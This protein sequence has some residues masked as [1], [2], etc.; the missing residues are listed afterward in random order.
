MTNFQEKIWSVKNK[1][2]LVNLVPKLTMCHFHRVSKELKMKVYFLQFWSDFTFL[3]IF[4]FCALK[5]EQVISCRKFMKFLSFLRTFN[6][7]F[8]SLWKWHHFNFGAKLTR[9][10]LLLND[11]IFSGKFPVNEFHVRWFF[12]SPKM[13]VRRVF[14]FKFDDTM[15]YSF[16]VSFCNCE[17]WSRKQ[18]EQRE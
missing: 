1:N 14:E 18:K 8:E 16:K 15:V 6:S 7:R 5:V 13:R 3:F 10:F 2:L 11:Q 12:Q 4:I 17:S 9:T